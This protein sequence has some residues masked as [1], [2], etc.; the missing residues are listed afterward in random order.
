M[1]ELAVKRRRT[2]GSNDRTYLNREFSTDC[3]R[4]LI[5]SLA[6]QFLTA[7]RF[8]RWQLATKSIQL[9]ANSKRTN[10]F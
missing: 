4:N 1:K 9:G 8:F 2:L 10:E 6:K 3:L 5:E 7:R